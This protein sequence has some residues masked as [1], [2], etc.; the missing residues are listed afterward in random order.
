MAIRFLI[1]CR[2]HM[3]IFA[4][5]TPQDSPTLQTA[6]ASAFPDNYLRV[7]PGQYL[8][9][10]RGT[11]VDVS[12]ALGITDGTNGTGIVLSTSAYYGR[13]GNNIWEWLAVKVSTP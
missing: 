11:A 3:I 1:A 10:S 8:V 12:N 5:M 7:G 9:A 2:L 13:A 6:M 4:I